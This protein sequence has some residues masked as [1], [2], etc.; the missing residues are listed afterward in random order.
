[1]VVAAG[2]REEPV[3]VVTLRI[4]AVGA[5]R[6]YKEHILKQVDENDKYDKLR[7]FQDNQCE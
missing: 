6:E 4:W 7:E 3:P 5:L 1:M 2:F